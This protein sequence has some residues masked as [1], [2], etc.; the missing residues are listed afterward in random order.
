[1]KYNEPG[2]D[3]QFKPGTYSRSADMEQNSLFSVMRGTKKKAA[4]EAAAQAIFTFCGFLAV[5]AVGVI[6]AY[7]IASGTPALARAGWKEILFGTVWRP[8]GE[9]PRYGIFYCI[10]SSLAGTL[11][12]VLIGAP[13][14]VLTAVF[15]AELAD[16]RLAGIL[17]AAVELLAGIPSVIYGLL[18]IYLLNPMMYR[19]ERWIFAGSETHQFTG[20][21]NLLSASLILAVM[22]LPTVVNISEA[23]I[24]AVDPGIRRASLAL[25]ASRIQT[26][27]GSVLPAAKPG[28]M[29]A[30]VLGVGRALGEAMAITLASGNSVN[31]PLPFH[32]VR[33]LTSAIVSEMGYAG[34]LHRQVLFTIGLVLFGFIMVINLV[35]HRILKGEGRP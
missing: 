15:L 1:M 30:V 17:R 7:M 20:G 24:R 6:V 23:A 28:I 22:I 8:G 19:L 21:A 26:I 2:A 12:A 33:F 35:L 31:F 29:T 13:V 9:E 34:G 5:L 14:G 4:V 25:G 10:L 3:N 11:L 27:F 16:K 18:G 32:S